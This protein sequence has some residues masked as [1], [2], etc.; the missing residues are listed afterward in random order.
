MWNRKFAVEKNPQYLHWRWQTYLKHMHAHVQIEGQTFL[1]KL[2]WCCFAG[3]LTCK[4]QYMFT[5]LPILICVSR[6]Q[7]C[8]SMPLC[9][10]LAASLGAWG[11]SWLQGAKKRESNSR[12]HGGDLIAGPIE[13]LYPLPGM[14][15]G[16][17]RTFTAP[18]CATHYQFIGESPKVWFLILLWR[19][20]ATGNT[21]GSKPLSQDSW[22]HSYQSGI[23][24]AINPHS[25]TKLLQQSKR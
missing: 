9:L 12:N 14:L 3:E 2:Y 17:S 7:K 16:L 20:A 18:I 8:L 22:R 25:S 1:S 10:R 23:I 13:L 4:R 15:Q 21:T 24:S 6:L 5:I 19:S 11:T